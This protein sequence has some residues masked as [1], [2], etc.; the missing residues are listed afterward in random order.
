VDSGLKVAS[1][2]DEDLTLVT[3]RALGKVARNFRILPLNFQCRSTAQITA[4]SNG[5]NSEGI[6]LGWSA[7]GNATGSSMSIVKYFWNNDGWWPSFYL[8]SCAT[9]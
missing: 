8:P 7:F 6:F 3:P 1:L 5:E 9:R 2:W 4:E